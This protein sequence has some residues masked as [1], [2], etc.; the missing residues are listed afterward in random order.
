MPTYTVKFPL[1]AISKVD[2]F[3]MLDENNIKEVVKF[4]IKST[5]LTSPGERRSDP[6][7]GVGAKTYLFDME[8]VSYSMLRSRI[9]SQIQEYVP[10]CYVEELAVEVSNNVPNAINI[11]LK[12]IIAE[13][14]KVDNFE[15]SISI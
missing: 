2:T 6:N 7:F 14:N 10:Y 4:N 3:D 8:N 9:L 12:Y 1:D 11:K 13:I 5:I 15:L